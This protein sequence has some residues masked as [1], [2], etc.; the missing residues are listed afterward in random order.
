V[1]TFIESAAFANALAIYLDDDEYGDLQQ[2]MMGNP[3]VGRVIPGSGGVRKLRWKQEGSGK[4]GGLRV[5][6][7]VQ[8]RPNEFWML[9]LYSKSRQSNIPANILKR[10][11]ESFNK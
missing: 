4:R 2:F 5:I 10:M 1:F 7:Y 6:Y 9:T 11:K 3:E 8:Y